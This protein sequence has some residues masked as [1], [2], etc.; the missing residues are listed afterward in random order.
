MK[1]PVLLTTLSLAA[2]PLWAANNAETLIQTLASVGREG[3]GNEQAS[4]AWKAAVALGPNALGAVLS[5]T[6]TGNPVADNWLRC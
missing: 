4:A 3:D 5:Q 1:L 6:G 2:A